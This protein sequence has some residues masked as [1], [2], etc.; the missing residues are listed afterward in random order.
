MKVKLL[1]ALVSCLALT[2]C[3]KSKEESANVA[4][5]GATQTETVTTEHTSVTG[6]DK[7]ADAD[8]AQAKEK[9]DAAAA[10]AAAAEQANKPATDQAPATVSTDAAPAAA[11]GT[12]NTTTTTTTTPAAPAAPAAPAPHDNSSSAPADTNEM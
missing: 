11:P 7:Q 1:V 3:N 4:D 2:A 9:A 8:A 5:D 10:S 6:H 12:S